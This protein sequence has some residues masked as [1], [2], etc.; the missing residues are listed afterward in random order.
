MVKTVKLNN[1]RFY[2][3]HGFFPEEQKAGNIFVLNIAVSQSIKGSLT[4]HLSE[5][6]DYVQ[7]YD[8][9]K[10]EMNITSK[11]LEDVLQRI[12]NQV[13]TKYNSLANVFLS[14]KKQSPPFGGNCES[15]EVSIKKEY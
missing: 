3:R 12:L 13:E 7:L 5:T 1:L 14:I 6:I 8:I 9:S 11:L 15:S 10:H 4:D 2:A